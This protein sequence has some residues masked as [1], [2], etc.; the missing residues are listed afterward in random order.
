[1]S[2]ASQLCF[3]CTLFYLF[4]NF[5]CHTTVHATEQPLHCLAKICII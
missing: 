1:M 2:H 5:I 4:I 3:I